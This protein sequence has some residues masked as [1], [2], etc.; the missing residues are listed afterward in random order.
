[1]NP[2]NAEQQVDESGGGMGEKREG[3]AKQI[4]DSFFF[5]LFFF[6]LSQVFVALPK[7]LPTRANSPLSPRMQSFLGS[8]PTPLTCSLQ[9]ETPGTLQSS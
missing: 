4:T 2:R 8:V 3:N 1:M 9:D 6:F 7:P 5:L